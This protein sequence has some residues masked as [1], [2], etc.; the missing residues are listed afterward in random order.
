MDKPGAEKLYDSGKEPTIKKLLEFDAKIKNLKEKIAQLEKDS[1]NSSKPPSSDITKKPKNDKGKDGNRNKQKPGGQPGHK[2][3]NR[4]LV[5][6]EQ[7]NKIIPYYPDKGDNCQRELLSNDKA[8]TTD[9]IFRWQVFDIE[10]I[11]PKIIEYQA[12]TTICKCGC[13][14]KA[15]IPE[16][17]LKSNFGEHLMALIA[18]LTAVLHI[19]RRGIQEFCLTFLNTKICLGTIQKILEFSSRSLEKTVE[20]LENELPKSPVINADETG[21]NKQWL[22]IFVTSKFMLFNVAKSRSSSV[23]QSVLGNLYTGIL[24]VDRW[25]AYTKYHKGLFQICWAHLKRDFQGLLDTGKAIDSKDTII[26]AKSL[27]RLRKRL[28]A[29]WYKYKDQ[30]IK[31]NQL[32]K[33]AENVINLIKQL[34]EKYNDSEEKQAKSFAKNLLKR[35]DDLFTFIYYEDVEPTNNISE[36]GLRPAVQW[37]K[38][39]FGSR[40]DNGSILTSRLLTIVRT[41]WLQQR[42]PLEFL[43]DS[44]KAYKNGSPMLSLIK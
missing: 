37:R 6:L 43:A 10:P 1:H 32:I 30:K 3:K 33:E 41:C 18:Y 39:C 38:I 24:C 9:E 31:R 12:Y 23:L 29:I 34:L 8:N 4:E 44:I 11:K 42:N 27:E 20:E 17:I 19:S 25:G 14:T 13:Q 22:W 36:R 40:S 5:P 2:G 7:V 16:D 21:W 35:S 26:F 28:M 15:K